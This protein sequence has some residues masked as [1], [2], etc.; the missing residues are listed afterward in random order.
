MN[1]VIWRFVIKERMPTAIIESRI[2]TQ[3]E[4]RQVRFDFKRIFFRYRSV[5]QR[6]LAKRLVRYE[7]RRVSGPNVLIAYVLSLNE[8][9]LDRC[10]QLFCFVRDICLIFDNFRVVVINASMGCKQ[11]FKR[12]RVDTGPFQMSRDGIAILPCTLSLELGKLGQE[13]VKGTESVLKPAHT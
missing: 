2:E 10:S 8:L 3:L 6:R 1:L 4:G 13:L 5:Y 12:R 11:T 7:Q 9:R